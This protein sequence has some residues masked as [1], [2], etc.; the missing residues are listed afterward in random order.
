M[1][2][3]SPLVVRYLDALNGGGAMVGYSDSQLLERFTATSGDADRTV[4][5][6]AFG[7][8][9]ERHGR[10]VWH[11]CRSLVFD[12]H[13]AEDAFQATFLVLLMKAS[14]LRVRQTLGPWLHAVAYRTALNCRSTSTRRRSVER[15]AAA[16]ALTANRPESFTAELERDELGGAIHQA[17]MELPARFRA[18]VVLCDLEG[19]GYVEAA[20]SL[21]IPLGTLQ[22]RLARARRILRDKLTHHGAILPAVTSGLGSP[23]VNVINL[24][25]SMNPPQTL[26]RRTC[27]LA[28]SYIENYAHLDAVISSSIRE[29]TSNGSRVMVSSKLNGIAALL[30]TAMISGGVIAFQKQTSAHAGASTS[31]QVIESPRQLNARPQV[32]QLP[33]RNLLVTPAPLELKVATGQGKARV[34]ALDAAGNRIP[35]NGGDPRSPSRE[36]RLDIRWAVMTGVVDHRAIHRHFA[37]GDDL[38]SPPAETIYRRVDLARQSQERGSWSGWRTVDKDD[39][40]YRILDNLPERTLERTDDEFRIV[41]LVDPV[42]ILVAEVWKG[43]DVERLVPHLRDGKL[44][45][46][47][48]ETEQ[49]KRLVRARPPVLMIR[50]FDFTVEAGKTY[51]YRARLIFLDPVEIRRKTM[52][53][54]IRGPWSEPTAPVEVRST[55]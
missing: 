13:D 35:V 44:V 30:V 28:A 37:D 22:S 19:L 12:D 55:E 2:N 46:P 15:A 23:G 31:P 45:D 54:E 11:V 20:T 16:T 18:V 36:E 4:A 51:R 10:M 41:N 1:R 3:I 24:A 33:D 40:K 43:L 47:L 21:K 25:M 7:S 5:E 8:L 48:R 50:A 39:K 6:L 29:L 17:I 14:S 26:L 9:V 34:Y 32:T 42:P 27:H 53:L 49:P 38:A 52:G